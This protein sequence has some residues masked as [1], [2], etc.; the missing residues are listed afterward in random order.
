MIRADRQTGHNQRMFCYF[1][2]LFLVYTRERTSRR[3]VF[4]LFRVSCCVIISFV[5]RI[6][7]LYLAHHHI[8]THLLIA[9]RH[10]NSFTRIACLLFPSR[11]LGAIL[12]V[13]NVQRPFECIYK[14]KIV[15]M[16]WSVLKKYI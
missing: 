16:W 9:V 11:T 12:C 14:K 1:F 2:F 8:D 6:P 4:F 15:S 3:T 10:R 5:F 13:S 7:P